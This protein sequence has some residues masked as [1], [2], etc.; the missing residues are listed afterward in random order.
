MLNGNKTASKLV[1]FQINHNTDSPTNKIEIVKTITSSQG[2]DA[3][4]SQPVV[5]ANGSVF[6]IKDTILSKFDTKSKETTSLSSSM[7]F[8]NESEI[9]ANATNQLI[10]TS[11][12]GIYY[13]DANAANPKVT[14]VRTFIATNEPYKIL[15]TADFDMYRFTSNLCDFIKSTFSGSGASQQELS[16]FK[17]KTVYFYKAIGIK[18]GVTINDNINTILVANTIQIKKNFTVKKGANVSFKIN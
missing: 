17:N 10:I 11:K 16:G 18:N 9:I 14:N 8:S 6:L 5:T 4:I 3:G 7:T 13:V 15:M 12:S 1:V 2:A